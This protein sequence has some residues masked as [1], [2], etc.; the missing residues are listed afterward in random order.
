MQS[1]ERKDGSEILL[2]TD[3]FETT[4]ADDIIQM[5]NEISRYRAG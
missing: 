2:P 4:F 5:A 3:D 1:L